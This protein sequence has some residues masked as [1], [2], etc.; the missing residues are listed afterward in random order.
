[1]LDETRLFA[2][3]G[4]HERVAHPCWRRSVLAGCGLWLVAKFALKPRSSDDLY[5]ELEDKDPQITRYNG[6]SRLAI[7]AAALGA[8]LLFIASV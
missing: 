3:I 1:M 8:L 7:A 2:M 6:Y 4:P 5:Y